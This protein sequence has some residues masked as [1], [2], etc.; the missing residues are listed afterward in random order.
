MRDRIARQA[1]RLA[2]GACAGVLSIAVTGVAGA[3][4]APACSDS[5][6]ATLPIIERHATMDANST[7]VVLLTGDGGWAAADERVAE[8]L[9]ARGAAVVGVSMRAYLGQRRT[10][11]ESARDLECVART[12]LRHWQRTRLLVLGYSRG[13]DIAPF[14]VSRWPLELRQRVNMVA[15]VSLGESANFQFHLIDLVRDV[16]RDDDIPVADELAKLRGLRVICIY[17]TEE[18]GSGCRA[19]DTT[20]VTRYERPGGHRL[21]G[22]FD[23]VAGILEPGLRVPNADQVGRREPIRPA[24]QS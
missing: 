14:V 5:L 7:L 1:R 11:D 12:Y 22:G 8:G 20:V 3:Q 2:R 23:A 13:A 16:R 21:T 17:G 19:A 6:V 24:P 10:P 9:L 15:L 18:K 4:T